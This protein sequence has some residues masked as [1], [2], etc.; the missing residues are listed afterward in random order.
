VFPNYIYPI[1]FR[2]S[3]EALSM[4]GLNGEK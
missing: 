2:F 3:V 1:T 4:A